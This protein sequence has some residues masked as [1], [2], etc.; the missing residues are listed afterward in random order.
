MPPI[1][2]WVSLKF[3]LVD[4]AGMALMACHVWPLGWLIGFGKFRISW[5]FGKRLTESQQRGQYKKRE[6][7]NANDC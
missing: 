5:C 6:E 2:Y 3:D 4:G 7:V 1:W